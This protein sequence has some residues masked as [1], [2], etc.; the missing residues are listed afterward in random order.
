MGTL[1]SLVGTKD[2]K[3]YSLQEIVDYYKSNGYEVT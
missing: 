1:K 3:G 2:Y